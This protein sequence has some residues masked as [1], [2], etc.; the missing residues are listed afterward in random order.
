MD[1]IKFYVTKVTRNKKKKNIISTS[2]KNRNEQSVKKYRNIII[3]F[4]NKK[5]DMIKSCFDQGLRYTIGNCDKLYAIEYITSVVSDCCEKA[6]NPLYCITAD[7]K[8]ISNKIKTLE[9]VNMMCEKYTEEITTNTIVNSFSKVETS[10][11]LFTTIRYI[12]YICMKVFERYM[13]FEMDFDF[14]VKN[15]KGE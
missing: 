1:V 7:V 13:T 14:D 4:M 9:Y 6:T 15:K 11:R 8:S 3:D 10:L 2:D 5:D 12:S